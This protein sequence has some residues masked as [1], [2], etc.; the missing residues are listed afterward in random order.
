MGGGGG[1][2]GEVRGGAGR[3][4]SNPPASL[5][6]WSFYL[7]YPRHRRALPFFGGW[8]QPLA[9]GLVHFT[10]A[11]RMVWAGAEPFLPEPRDAA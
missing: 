7:L 1:E 8:R 2:A 5:E 4:E 9:G 10:G 3:R 6:G 11:R